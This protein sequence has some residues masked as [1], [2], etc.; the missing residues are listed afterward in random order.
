MYFRTLLVY[1]FRSYFSQEKSLFQQQF[2]CNCKIMVLFYFTESFQ[3]I[4]FRPSVRP[5]GVEI[6]TAGL[7]PY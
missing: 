3:D 5:S 1:D 4:G 2:V 6:T 7:R